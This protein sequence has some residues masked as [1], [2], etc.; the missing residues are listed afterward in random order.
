MKGKERACAST[1]L[2]PRRGMYPWIPARADCSHDPDDADRPQ[3]NGPSSSRRGDR[4]LALGFR[5]L[6]GART[7]DYCPWG[8]GR[9]GPDRRAASG[10]VVGRGSARNDL[11]VYQPPAFGRH[12]PPTGR[13]RGADAAREARA[14]PAGAWHGSC[15]K[16]APSAGFH[17][18]PGPVVAALSRPAHTPPR[19]A[20]PQTPPNRQCGGVWGFQ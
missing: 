6:P 16:P 20:K 3:G 11:R 8:T 10:V 2:F 1:A 19:Q 13:T 4:N 14:P 5:N 15:W 17:D 18:P 9:S 12:R 7:Q